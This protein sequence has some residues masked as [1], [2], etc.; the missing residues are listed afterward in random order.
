MSV[1]VIIRKSNNFT[2]ELGAGGTRLLTF[3]G[4]GTLNTFGTGLAS[5]KTTLLHAIE[6]SGWQIIN[7]SV[8]DTGSLWNFDGAIRP[9]SITL[10]ANVPDAYTNQQHYNELVRLINSF[11]AM[12]GGG[13]SRVNQ[14]QIEFTGD[15]K[16]GARP[17]QVIP[18]TTY[19]VNKNPNSGKKDDS[20]MPE[21]PKLPDLSDFFNPVKMFGIAGLTIGTVA[22]VAILYLAIRN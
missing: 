13:G 8:E 19:A 17:A 14:L 6:R 18:A 16:P 21:L 15:D 20:K 4:S 5:F 1:T 11:S 9:F 2:G 22:G 3:T 10:V 7:L 12:F